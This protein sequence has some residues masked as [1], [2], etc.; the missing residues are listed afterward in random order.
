[1]IRFNGRR[2]YKK[3]RVATERI[4]PEVTWS[5]ADPDMLPLCAF[6]I[7][8]TRCQV[9]IEIGAWVAFVLKLKGKGTTGIDLSGFK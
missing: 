9:S 1:M 6:E 2:G 4:A 7:T 5:E 8:G 3:L